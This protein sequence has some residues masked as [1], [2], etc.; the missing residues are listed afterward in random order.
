MT[1]T[2]RPTIR[3]LARQL[4][5]SRTTVSEALREHPRVNPE[6]RKRVREAAETVGYRCNPLASSI[7]SEVRRTQLGRFKGVLAVITMEEPTRPK[8][9][10]PYWKEMIRGAEERADQLGFKLERF[11]VGKSGVSLHRLDT[12]MQSRGIRG[13][14]IMPAWNWL[15]VTQ[16]DW[17][18]YTGVYTDYLID[19]PAL[20]SVCPDHPRAMM[21]AMGK[22]WELGYRRPGLVLL[23]QDSVRLQH[24][25]V[26][27]FLAAQQY[28]KHA[29]ESLPPLLLPEITR[30]G[31][32]QWFREAKPDVVIGHRPEFI[33]WMTEC[34][35][36][37]PETH[38][39]CCLNRSLAEAPCAGIDQMPYHVGVR[40]IETVIGQLHRNDYGIPEIPCNTTVPSHWVDGPTLRPTLVHA[41]ALRVG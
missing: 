26:A 10:A 18:R 6:T 29:W 5:L 38:G 11:L 22:L 3:S 14:L 24:R 41:T 34:G 35:A 40:A 2:N 31:F 15:D 16:L 19:R 13:L 27:A 1:E 36:R 32:V 37:V 33:E 21:L 8:F 23:E 28:S 25:W 12:V 4:G 9:A 39:F 17:S 7:L 30:E 20:H